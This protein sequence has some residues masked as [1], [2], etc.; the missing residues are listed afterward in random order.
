MS[1]ARTAR[2]FRDILPTEALSRERVCAHVQEVFSSWGYVP[3]ETPTLELASALEAAGPLDHSSF[4]LFDSDGELLVLRPDVTLPIARL[5]GTRMVDY[6]L[7]LRLR[8]RQTVFREARGWRGQARAFTQIGVEH[9]GS[10]AASADI[11]ILLMLDEALQQSGL[12]DY[13]IAFC[14]VSPL[15]CLLGRC[16]EQGQVGGD[17]EHAVLAACHDNDLVAVDGLSRS[18]GVEVA[19]GNALR[20]LVRLNG[21]AE[22]VEQARAIMSGIGGDHDL[23]LLERSFAEVSQKRPQTRFIIDFSV[24]SSFDYYTGLV[25]AAYAPG[26][27]IPLASGGRYDHTLAQFGLAAPAAGFALHLERIIDTLSQDVPGGAV[28]PSGLQQAAP[29]GGG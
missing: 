25:L 24:M 3:V 22:A 28:C 11:E 19:Y 4:K 7:P 6:Q 27:G 26:L 21:G 13:A 20:A 29:G 14:S 8:Y 9:I 15:R 17:W 10:D 16:C 5:V 23:L 1:E 12:A 18:P 2:G